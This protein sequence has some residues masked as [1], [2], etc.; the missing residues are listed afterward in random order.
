MRDGVRSAPAFQGQKFADACHSRHPEDRLGIGVQRRRRV[1][2]TRGQTATI[3]TSSRRSGSSAQLR[4]AAN[5]SWD[6]CWRGNRARGCSCLYRR[7]AV[8]AHQDAAAR[9]LQMANES[10][11]HGRAPGGASAPSCPGHA[12]NA[13]ST[14][15]CAVRSLQTDG[16]E[17]AGN[18]DAPECG[19]LRTRPNTPENARSLPLE[20][21][22]RGARADM[23][24]GARP[25]PAFSGQ[26][27]ITTRHCATTP[28]DATKRRRITRR[29]FRWRWLRSLRPP[30]RSWAGAREARLPSRR[31]APQCRSDRRRTP[32]KRQLR[33]ATISQR[34]GATL[35]R[36][37]RSSQRMRPVSATAYAPCAAASG[38]WSA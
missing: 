10:G 6:R 29:R 19:V 37:R 11:R 5:W 3:W 36:G 8:R 22:P 12:R 25:A 14:F 7:R 4:R 31:G 27:R 33:R 26:K 2:R 1:P 30:A 28:F 21:S 34:S 35:P 32:D 9:S 38:L 15:E 13:P 18:E 20:H 17:G 16:G 23:R 24:D